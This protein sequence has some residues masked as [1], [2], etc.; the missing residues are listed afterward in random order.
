MPSTPPQETPTEHLLRR[1]RDALTLIRTT[2]THAPHPPNATSEAEHGKFHRPRGLEHPYQIK[3]VLD[4]IPEIPDSYSAERKYFED[5]IFLI[6][7]QYKSQ[8][9]T[10]HV[11]TFDFNNEALQ[12]FQM[13]DKMFAK[14][15]RIAL[16][17]DVKSIH[18]AVH[19]SY[20]HGIP[21]LIG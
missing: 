7:V 11:W 10:R 9:A 2:L 12:Y 8:I 20:F 21:R 18:Q 6:T 4:L 1:M 17:D 16:G 3:T 14:T 15:R 19:D 13:G 5:L